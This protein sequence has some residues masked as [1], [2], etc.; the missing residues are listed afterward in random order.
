MKSRLT[1]MF[2]VFS[3]LAG[4]GNDAK[5]EY[6]MQIDQLESQLDSLH[7]VI[8]NSESDRNAEIIASVK[9]TLQTIKEGYHSDTIEFDLAKKLDS[10]K[11]I[12]TALSTN[13]GNLA[14]TKQAVLETQKSLGDLKHDIDNGVNNRSEYDGFIEFEKNKLSDITKLWDYYTETSNEY[15]KRYD[16]L[17]SYVYD[18]SLSLEIEHE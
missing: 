4:C 11:E 5:K 15:Q 9:K 18:Y 6:L 13:S 1:L 17:H 14:K 2:L 10:Y 8:F 12:E 16:T 3:F 7:K